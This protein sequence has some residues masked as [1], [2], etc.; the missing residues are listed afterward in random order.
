MW[1][2]LHAKP[3]RGEPG[4]HVQ[5]CIDVKFF[6]NAVL[7]YNAGLFL[8]DPPLQYLVLQ[9]QHPRKTPGSSHRESTMS[10]AFLDTLC[11]IIC[12]LRTRVR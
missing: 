1:V 9:W 11:C 7:Q 3:V 2:S 12:V 6:K 5:G 8:M 10:F 4:Q